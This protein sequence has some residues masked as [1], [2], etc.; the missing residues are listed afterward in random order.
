MERTRGT[1]LFESHLTLARDGVSWAIA[2]KT[3]CGGM[4]GI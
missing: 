3:L 4:R 2:V 1:A